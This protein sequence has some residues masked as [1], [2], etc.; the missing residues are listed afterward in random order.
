ML[1]K[2]TKKQ[3]EII[4]YIYHF[5]FLNR[6][7]IQALLNH[8]DHK[9]TNI[10]LKDLTEKEYLN[11]NYS[12]KFYENTKP[13]IY[14]I[15]INGIKLIRTL[16]NCPRSHLVKLYREKDRLDSFAGKCQLLADI[17]IDLR[18]KSESKKKYKVVTSNA[19]SDPDSIY[20]FL[21][22][23]TFDLLI[24]KTSKNKEYY[25]L[26][27]FDQNLPAHKIRK[28]IKD[29]IDFY[30]SNIWEDKVG[31]DFPN[32]ILVCETLPMVVAIKKMTNK[33]VEENELR[34]LMHFVTKKE[35]LDFAA[36]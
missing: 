6:V 28:R 8:K 12:T 13:A 23:T 24:E 22:D 7:Q 33:F 11:R 32:V 25:L 26:E 4:K 30:F 31:G 27:V 1:P 21:S 36:F 3:Q 10:W 2:I 35:N 15:G 9:T 20:N 14:Y 5:R 34:K 17:Y 29:Y 16:V 19:F 18:A